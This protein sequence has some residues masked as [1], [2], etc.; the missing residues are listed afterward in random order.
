MSAEAI[1]RFALP[2]LA[3]SVFFGLLAGYWS[4]RLQSTRPNRIR[5]GR[6]WYVFCVTFVTL[7]AVMLVLLGGTDGLVLVLVF[8]VTLSALALADIASMRAPFW[9]SGVL[10]ASGLIFSALVSQAALIESA[11]TAALVFVVFQMIRRGYQRARERAGMGGGDPLAAAGLGAW[12][13]A[14]TPYALLLAALMAL[15]VA[16]GRRSMN[17][18]L[19]FVPFLAVAGFVAMSG[20][21]IL[22][23][24]PVGPATVLS[25]GH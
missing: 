23:G 3:V 17:V 18:P 9:V 19:A 12:L 22:L 14:A 24:Q 11:F 7:P 25:Q 4:R 1:G 16:Y 15:V 13:G 5:D 8:W 2:V 21:L 10:V 6:G 20:L